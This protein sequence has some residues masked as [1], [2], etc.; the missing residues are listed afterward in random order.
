MADYRLIFKA[1]RLS[2]HST[3][4]SRVIKKKKKKTNAAPAL[5]V[6]I[7]HFAQV[8]HKWEIQIQV[9]FC[10]CVFLESG[11][12]AGVIRTRSSLH[13]AGDNKSL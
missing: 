12:T 3:L 1:Q 7:Q 10:L 6:Q 4:G 2:H 8:G 9:C 13:E 5:E 11:E